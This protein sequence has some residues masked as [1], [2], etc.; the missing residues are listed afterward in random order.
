MCV[1]MF[2]QT[3]MLALTERGLGSCAQVSVTGYQEV[4][5]KGFG[6]EEDQDLLCGLALG[7]PDWGQKINSI[8]VGRMEGEGT[9]VRFLT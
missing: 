3:F 6:V 8:V 4:I 9:G 2:L 1:G 7:W 5:R